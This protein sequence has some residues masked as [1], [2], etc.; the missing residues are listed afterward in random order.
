MK[1]YEVRRVIAAQPATLWAIISD[2]KALQDGDFGIQRIEGDIFANARI[3]LWAE[4]SPKRAFSLRV[5]EFEPHRRM[6]WRSG[7]PFGLFTGERQFNLQEVEG[8]TEFHVRE[9]FSGLMLGLIWKSMPDLQPSFDQFANAL[10]E[11]AKGA[12]T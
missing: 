10:Q 6:V 4:I 3:K 7:M 2:A 11:Q 9:E 1:F 5:T 8:G 12:S